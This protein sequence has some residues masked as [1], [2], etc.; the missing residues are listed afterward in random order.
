MPLIDEVDYDKI[1][2]IKTER[3]VTPSDRLSQAVL[4]GEA[5]I[6][7]ER[8][9]TNSTD[10]PRYKTGKFKNHIV[11]VTMDAF[12]DKTLYEK[13]NEDGI[14][15]IYG[16]ELIDVF[17]RAV[18]NAVL[19]I[20]LAGNAY[21]TVRQILNV[22][23]GKE[24][25]EGQNY[26]EQQCHAV[27]FSLLKLMSMKI[28]IDADKES[29]CFTYRG[30]PITKYFGPLLKIERVGFSMNGHTIDGYRYMGNV[31]NLEDLPILYQYAKAK[32]EIQTLPVNFLNTPCTK[33]DFTIRLQ[34]CLRY[35]IAQMTP[36]SKISNKITAEYLE[37]ELK[38]KEMQD[39]TRR[40]AKKRM[41]DYTERILSEWVK[42]DVI[43]SYKWDFKKNNSKVKTGVLIFPKKEKKSTEI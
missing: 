42:Q 40:V 4:T 27:R 13:H 30:H 19:S 5:Q 25:S 10:A 17:D 31:D 20:I 28:G 3:Y 1:T 7:S 38:F 34:E 2:A 29:N 18:Y 36:S 24:K 9:K 15:T 26:T 41:W 6:I 11:Y 16:K 12:L 22:M 37:K 21:I 43:K 39:S 23:T 14:F 33:S 32:G 8:Y 35:R